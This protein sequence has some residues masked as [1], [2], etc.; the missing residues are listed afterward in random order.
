[1]EDILNH[2]GYDNVYDLIKDHTDPLELMDLL[3]DLIK[4]P[5]DAPDFVKEAVE[6]IATDIFEWVDLEQ[7]KADADEEAYQRYRDGD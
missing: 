4:S 3:E 6:A 5:L 2:C 1:M 7:I